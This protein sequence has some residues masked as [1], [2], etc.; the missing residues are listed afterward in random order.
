MFSP[1]SPRFSIFKL[2]VPL[3]SAFEQSA[4][5]C[6]TPLCCIFSKVHDFLRNRSFEPEIRTFCH[7]RTGR[8]TFWRFS[9]KCTSLYKTAFSERDHHVLSYF[10]WLHHFLTLFSE[11]H[12]FVQ[13]SKAAF[14]AREQHVLSFLHWA[15]HF[16]AFTAKC[17][18]LYK[19]AFSERDQHVLS[20]SHWVHH[21]LQFSAK[22]TSLC[23][24]ASSARVEHVFL[25]SHWP[26]HHFPRGCTS[27]SKTGFSAQ[28]QHVFSFSHW[29][30]HVLA[31]FSKVHEF[32]QNSVS[33]PRSARTVIFALGAPLLNSFQ[34]TARVFPKSKTALLARDQH[35]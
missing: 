24:T 5:V 25:I 22:C 9:A 34:Q 31:F 35:V 30:Q 11:V 27:L 32:V 19:T 16:L 7:F 8:T 12:E 13:N 4:R 18:S 29:V 33:S 17:T 23:K 26:V 20:F 21:F 10:P 6:T 2:G 1:R 28:D 15:H 14:S 3:F